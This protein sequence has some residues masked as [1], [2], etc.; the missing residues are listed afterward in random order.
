MKNLTLALLFSIALISCESNTESE[1]SIE[2]KWNV[3]QIIGGFMPTKNYNANEFTW[4]FDLNAK[5]VTI[6]NNVD[7]F[8]TYHMPT[9]TNNRGGT[10]DFEIITENN[11]NYL[12]V[13]DRKGEIKF[14]ESGL[15]I[16]YG[17]AFDDVAY[18]F[19]R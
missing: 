9:F 18:I 19:K 15:T 2:G 17:I 1:N 6:Q 11:I 12:V 4:L 16:D 3:S 14:T 13:G 8:D 7:V 5:T 10:Y